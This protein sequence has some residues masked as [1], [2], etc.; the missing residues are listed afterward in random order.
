MRLFV[1]KVC[2]DY[3]SEDIIGIF[4]TRGAAEEAL[5]HPDLYKADYTEIEI[6]ELN[7]ITN[8]AIYYENGDPSN[9]ELPKKNLFRNKGNL[10]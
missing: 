3:E 2:A 1:A 6:C 7:E 10:L 4:E 8:K 5:S 9:D